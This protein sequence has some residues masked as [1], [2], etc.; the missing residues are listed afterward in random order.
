MTPQDWG[1]LKR[2]ELEAVST[3]D[4]GALDEEQ[5]R[6]LRELLEQVETSPDA[7]EAIC[8]HGAWALV[9]EHGGRLEDALRHR[10][11]EIAKIERLH[12]LARQNPGDRAALSN[13]SIDDLRLRQRILRDLHEA[14][15]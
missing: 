5:V 13:Y 11:I 4:S 7:D 12:D 1:K 8:Y 14:L 15:A 6:L 2:V 10:T 9:H 3:R